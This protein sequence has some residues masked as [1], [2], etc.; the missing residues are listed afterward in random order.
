[1]DGQAPIHR[2][3]IP[4]MNMC[5]KPIGGGACQGRSQRLDAITED[6]NYVTPEA[7]QCFGNT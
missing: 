6:D 4:A 5:Y 2:R 7:L 1:M 3:H